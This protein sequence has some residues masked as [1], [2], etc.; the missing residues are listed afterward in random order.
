M[1]DTSAPKTKSCGPAFDADGVASGKGAV[2]AYLIG[3][4]GATG[5]VSGTAVQVVTA[6]AI[7]CVPGGVACLKN[8]IMGGAVVP[9]DKGNVIGAGHILAH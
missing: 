7:I 8:D 4:A 6:P 3:P 9:H 2:I 1:A 5:R